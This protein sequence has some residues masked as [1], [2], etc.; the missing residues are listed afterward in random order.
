MALDGALLKAVVYIYIYIYIYACPRV[1]DGC[2]ARA[3][4]RLKAIMCMYVCICMCVYICV[5]MYVCPRMVD[6]YLAR[7]GQRWPS[8]GPY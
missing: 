2:L 7:A 3:G 8:M 6:D 4:R 5:Y 1:V